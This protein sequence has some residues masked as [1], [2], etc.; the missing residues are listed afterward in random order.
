MIRLNAHKITQ[1]LSSISKRF[2]RGKRSKFSF[3]KISTRVLFSVI[4]LFSLV[5]SSLFIQSLRYQFAL[6]TIN[7]SRDSVHF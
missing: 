5:S 1:N 6:K 3:Q 7:G 2:S 4:F